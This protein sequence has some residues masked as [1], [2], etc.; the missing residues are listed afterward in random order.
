MPPV[1]AWLVRSS[2]LCLAAGVTLGTALLAQK[3][4][5][6]VIGGGSS[7]LLV[8]RELV[9][10]GWLVQLAVGVGFWILPPVR[11]GAI[12]KRPAWAVAIL[13]DSGLLLFLAGALWGGGA[14]VERDYLLTAGRTLEALAI[15]GFGIPL[16]RK[17]FR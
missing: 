16:L 12:R 15:L 6:W 8:H 13:L 11:G 7:L 17:P 2:L 3:S 5:W 1:S 14:P 4:G 9:L 10:V